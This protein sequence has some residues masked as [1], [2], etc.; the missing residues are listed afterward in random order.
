MLSYG[1]LLVQVFNILFILGWLVLAVWALFDMRHR[2]MNAT[3]KALW[4]VI[5]L[6][7]PL[8]GALAFWIVAPDDGEALG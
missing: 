3:A 4:V 1:F 5:V 6:C 8:F 2:H 7:L